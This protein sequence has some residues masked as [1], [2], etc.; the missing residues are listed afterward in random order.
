MSPPKPGCGFFSGMRFISSTVPPINAAG[1][2]PRSAWKR[3]VCFIC[4]P[5]VPWRMTTSNLSAL[6]SG[7]SR[8]PRLVTCMPGSIQSAS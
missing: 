2:S 3:S 5:A 4:K 7:I 8:R 1:D 6:A